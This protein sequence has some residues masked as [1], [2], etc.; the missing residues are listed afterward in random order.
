MNW[1]GITDMINKRPK[2]ISAVDWGAT[3][4]QSDRYE[5]H[6][7]FENVGQQQEGNLCWTEICK[8]CG[9][10]EKSMERILKFAAGKTQHDMGGKVGNWFNLHTSNYFMQIGKKM[11]R[12]SILI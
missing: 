1:D 6:L 12:H 9:Y 2:D 3:M 7:N 4:I 10:N 5:I 8:K 11:I